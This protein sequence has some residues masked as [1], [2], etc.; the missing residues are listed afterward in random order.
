MP[1]RAPTTRLSSYIG[2]RMLQSSGVCA[3]A[4]Q[5]HLFVF[6]ALDVPILRP[7]GRRGKHMQPPHARAL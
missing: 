7:P 2:L 1:Q 5:G 4:G 3:H 6:K